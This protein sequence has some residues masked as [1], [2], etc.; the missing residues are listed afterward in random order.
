MKSITIAIL[1]FLAGNIFSQEDLFKKIKKQLKE[2]H[3]EMNIENKLI[4]VNVWSV[5]DPKSREA[6][7]QI[8]KAYTSYEFARLKGGSKGM[9][10]VLFCEDSDVSTATIILHKD[11]VLK[12]IVINND[13]YFN[14]QGISNIIFDSNG[15]VV[16]KNTTSDIFEEIHQLI[17]R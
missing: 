8:N 3:P 12:P 5:N 9:V 17:T 13:K 11:K 7:V 10:G 1:L 16:K 14:L 6:N 15:S 4:V 2:D